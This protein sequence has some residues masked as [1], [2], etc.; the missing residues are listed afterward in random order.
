MMLEQF[1]VYRNCSAQTNKTLP[2]YM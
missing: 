2:Y 1:N